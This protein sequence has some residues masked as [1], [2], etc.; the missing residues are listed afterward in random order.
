VSNINGLGLPQGLPEMQT[1]TPRADWWNID[2]AKYPGGLR[3]WEDIQRP[4][5]MTAEDLGLPLGQWSVEALESLYGD[6]A[7]W[8]FSYSPPD[9]PYSFWLG[10]DHG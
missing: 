3:F 7:D 8:F 5:E 2:P 4:R 9:A 1:G 10:A 6:L